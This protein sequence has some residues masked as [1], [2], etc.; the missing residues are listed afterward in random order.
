MRAEGPDVGAELAV[1]KDCET[2]RVTEP[3]RVIFIQRKALEHERVRATE[4]PCTVAAPFFRPPEWSHD[5]PKPPLPRVVPDLPPL[6]LAL[7]PTQGTLW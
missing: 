4:P 7:P 6:P 5:E 1:C 3:Y 2:L